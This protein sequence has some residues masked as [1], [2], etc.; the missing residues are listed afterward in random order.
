MEAYAPATK[1]QFE[2]SKK[3]KQTIC[4]YI[5]TF[6]VCFPSLAKNDIFCG[7]YKRQKKCHVNLTESFVFLNITQ[8]I[9][10]FLEKTL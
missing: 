2:V 10:V 6:Y 5:L 4:A 8:K 1:K 3:Y 9:L 7:V